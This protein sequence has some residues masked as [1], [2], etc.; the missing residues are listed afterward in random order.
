MKKLSAIAANPISFCFVHKVLKKQQKKITPE[1]KLA[2]NILLEFMKFRR[3]VPLDHSC[4]PTTCESCLAPHLNQVISAVLQNN[5]VH[6][7]LPAFPGKSPNPAKVFN[8]LPDM[9]EECALKFLQGLCLKIEKIYKPGAKIILCSD[10][11]VFSDVIGIKEDHVSAYKKEIDKIIAENKL[12]KISTLTMEDLFQENNFI[13]TR[14]K[15]VEQYASSTESLRERAR[16]GAKNSK[17]QK[18]K[19]AQRMYCGITRF[20]FEDSLVPGQTKSRTALQKESKVKAYEVI[21]RSNAWSELLA[22]KFPEAV[23]LSIHPQSCGSTKLGLMLLGNE[24]WL[25]PWHSVAIKKDNNFTL[26]KRWEAEK[27]SVQMIKNNE[28]RASYY[29]LL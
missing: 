26:M 18:D 5:P 12:T 2:K 24:S 28:G 15:L 10:G 8:H 23:R 7:I 14:K 6:F 19:E 11:R 25:T 29:K 1:K 27:L 3:M 21:R 22:E 13:K 9:A 17:D 4:S 20:L 16:R